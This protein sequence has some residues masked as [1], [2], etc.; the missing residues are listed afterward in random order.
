M[1][2]GKHRGFTLVELLVAMTTFSVVMGGVYAAFHDAA[3]FWRESE[4]DID[5]FQQ[6]RVTLSVLDRELRSMHE[7]AGFLFYGEEKGRR[8][9]RRDTLEFYTVS[10]PMTGDQQ[11][12]AQLMKVAYYIERTPRGGGFELRRREWL[13][14]GPLPKEKDFARAEHPDDSLVELGHG[15]FI[16]LAQHIESFGLSYYWPPPEEGV[17]AWFPAC[18]RGEGPPAVIRVD[19]ALTD[20]NRPSGKKKFRTSVALPCRPGSGPPRE[21]LDIDVNRPLSGLAGS[22][23]PLSGLGLQ[24]RLR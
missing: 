7:S 3:R 5:V 9:R 17:Q 18:E 15:E 16:V 20:A 22:R 21:P 2:A 1:T 4:Q 6:T 14:E 8:G 24:E 19:M 10:T 12:V 23:G 13:V 11:Q